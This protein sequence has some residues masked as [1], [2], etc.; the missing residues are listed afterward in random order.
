[1]RKKTSIVAA[2]LLLAGC[3]GQVSPTAASPSPSS[4]AEET[5]IDLST[6][7]Q[8]VVISQAGTYRLS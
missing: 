5:K 7:Q 2:M 4:A 6:Q 8:Q 3:G 1:M